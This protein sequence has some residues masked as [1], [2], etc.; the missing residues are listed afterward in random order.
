MFVF[1][2]PP[3]LTV[4]LSL[5]YTS[6]VTQVAGP[7]SALQIRSLIC[8]IANPYEVVAPANPGARDPELRAIDPDGVLDNVI[9]RR[10]LL[11][12]RRLNY[13]G[14]CVVD[15]QSTVPGVGVHR[16][17]YKHAHDAIPVES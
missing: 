13:F 3:Y 6:A 10:V 7:S 17:A 14:Y 2:S 8:G 4:S 9:R 1:G 12:Q 5:S 15:L 11:L 16:A